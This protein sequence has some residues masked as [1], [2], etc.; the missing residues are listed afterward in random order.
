MEDRPMLMPNDSYGKNLFSD[1][2]TSPGND[3]EGAAPMYV[4]NFVHKAKHPLF[5]VRWIQEGKKVITGAARG[6]II[7]W[8]TQAINS[9]NSQTSTVHS[10]TRVQS[11]AV[12]QYEKFIISGDKEGYIVY[13]NTKMKQKNKLVAHQNVVRDLSFSECS[14]KFVSCSDDNTAKV[15]DFTTAKAEFEFREHRSEVKSC[16]WHPTKSLILTGSKDF[17]VKLWDPR[18]GGKG[19]NEI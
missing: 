13:S 1:M 18:C 8:N 10:G 4:A 2:Y 6:D 9:Q 11:I 3:W 16:D 19:V 17:F 12:S 15:F 7:T 5:A 14:C